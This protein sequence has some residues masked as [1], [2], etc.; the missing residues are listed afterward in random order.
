MRADGKQM[1]SK[2]KIKSMHH[3]H[4]NQMAFD[5]ASLGFPSILGC[6]AICF[7]TSRGLYGFHDLKSGS[8][9]T[10]T[11]AEAG[12]AKL[13]TFANWV[14][15]LFQHGEVGVALFGVIN[16]DEQYNPDTAGNAE[17]KGVLLGLAGSL[18]FTG[19]VYGARIT[20]HLEK[21]SS[22]K[23]KS[24]Y[25]QFDLAGGNCR[26]G[27]K[28]WS[29]MSADFA[30]KVKPTVQNVVVLR[31]DTFQSEPLY[32]KGLVAPVVRQDPNKGFNLNP[33]ALKQFFKFQ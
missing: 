21:K 24:V 15:G 31:G 12:A 13:R 14:T 10:M 11:E 32:G 17:W 27:F 5:P 26:V 28:R 1:P 4:E 9:Q 22:D 7:H 29:K 18:V 6:Q 20:S 16:R 33:I 19:A 23:E 2:P 30:H 3:V 25:V 8:N